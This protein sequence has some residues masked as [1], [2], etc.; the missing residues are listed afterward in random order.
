MEK[1]KDPKYPNIEHPKVQFVGSSIRRNKVDPGPG[2][3][4][5]VE[6]PEG[7]DRK[8]QR[9]KIS[10]YRAPKSPVRRV[11]HKEKQGGPWSRV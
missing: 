6:N 9:S 11:L 7:P 5:P 3:M 8:I 1:F 2:L 4:S 10:K